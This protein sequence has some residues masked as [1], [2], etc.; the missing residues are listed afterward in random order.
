[1]RYRE[2]EPITVADAEPLLASDDPDVVCDALVRV[3]H[4]PVDP[5]WIEARLLDATRH[6]EPAV[7][8]TAATCLGHLARIH[9]RVTT[10]KVLPALRR[11]LKDPATAGVVED[12]LEDIQIFSKKP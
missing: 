7:R 4:S 12:A 5:A 6:A 2:P 10:K 11:L 3:V 8:G 9:G 1:M